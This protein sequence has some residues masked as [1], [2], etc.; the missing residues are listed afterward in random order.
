MRNTLLLFSFFFIPFV[1]RAQTVNTWE[2][3]QAKPGGIVSTV[4]QG[5]VTWDDYAA[6]GI[7][8]DWT[9]MLR[10]FNDEKKQAESRDAFE[11]TLS[12]GRRQEGIRTIKGIAGIEM[13]VPFI[14][15][16][17]GEDLFM[18]TQ[19]GIMIYLCLDKAC[20]IQEDDPDVLK[21]VRFYAYTK[22]EYTKKMF[23]RFAE[24]QSFFRSV[25]RSYG[26]PEEF[27][28]L[29]MVESG[30]TPSARSKAGALGMWQM[31]PATGRENGLVI[32][33][34]YDQRLDWQASTYAAARVLSSYYG[35]TKDWTLTAAAYNCGPGR[36][37]KQGRGLQ[38]MQIKG[39]LPQETSQYIPCLTALRY[40]WIYR[41]ELALTDS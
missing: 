10:E 32:I 25:F 1:L 29:C 30:C 41:K 31:M 36:I 39:R 3:D 14:P 34:G 5:N 16:P 19:D 15:G 24:K 18:L 21:W 27:A 26:V 37:Q 38:W 6:Q 8:S 35:I 12:L 23:R 7:L 2:E 9:D 13:K 22:R 4:E 11:V 28:E 20:Y 17:E 40:L 33:D